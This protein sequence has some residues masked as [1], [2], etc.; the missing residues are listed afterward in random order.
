MTSSVVQLPS[1]LSPQQ[2]AALPLLA[3]GMRY[4]EVAEQIQSAHGT[5]KNWC[6]Q[7]PHFKAEL[8]RLRRA[9][10]AE[11]TARLK[12]LSMDSVLALHTVLTDEKASHKDKIAAAKAVLAY[13]H[14]RSTVHKIAPADAANTIA[15][16][17][18]GLDDE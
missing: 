7:N 9:S 3:S 8:S 1:K 15:S 5:V 13:T 6:S 2:L 16:I 4:S 17:L 12:A 11:S 14:D 18:R 10:Y